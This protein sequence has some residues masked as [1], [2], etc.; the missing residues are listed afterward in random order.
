MLKTEYTNKAIFERFFSDEIF[1]SDLIA[2]V[3]DEFRRRNSGAPV[4]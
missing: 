1:R 4:A 2:G 3:G